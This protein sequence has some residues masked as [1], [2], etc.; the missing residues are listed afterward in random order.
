MR[1]AI[2]ERIAEVTSGL[3]RARATLDA[4]RRELADREGRAE[5]AAEFA[6]LGQSVTGALAACD[7]PREC[8]AQLATLLLRL[9]DL[10]ARF[11]DH[12]EFRAEI[13]ARRTEVSDAFAA[14]RQTLEDAAARRA[15][16]LAD[17]AARV[18][19]TLARRA[20]ALPDREAVATFFASEALVVKARRTADQLRALGESVR[21]EELAGRLAAAREDA[22][23]A[24][25]DRTELYADGGETIR[26]G[27]H[28]F[29][30][31]T[32][33]PELTLLPDADGRV[34]VLALTGTDYRA[35]VSDPAFAATRAYWR[36][37]LPSEAPDVYRAEHLAAR[38]LADHGA[39]ALSAATLEEL[40]EL[41]RR[42][43]EEA[44]DEGYERGVH[45][46]DATAILTAVLRL[47]E[48]AE[49]L[50]YPAGARARAALFWAHGTTEAAS[51]SWAREAVSLARARDAFGSA[52][53]L[54]AL[55][56]ELATTM[57]GFALATPD[58]DHA[59][60]AGGTESTAGDSADLA[61][62]YL[63]EE[64]ARGGSFVTGPTA[65][66]LLAAFGRAVGAAGD[67]PPYGAD[68]RAQLAAG[69][70]AA[71]YR[72][73]HGWLTAYAGAGARS[74]TVT[75]PRRWPSRSVRASTGGR[76]RRS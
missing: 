10:E 64:L 32:Q 70:P 58:A 26:L 2:L 36:Q 20:G 76:W 27:E 53:G 31:S 55:R 42:V 43:A 25:R 66:E 13:D 28:R 18:L 61:A 47:H 62:A 38:L 41:V 52:P 8:D 49:L 57:A 68:V 46:R 11:A 45:D 48:S 29:A 39:P 56:A 44:Y 30:V 17:S 12:E 15:A 33:T 59:P 69:E 4:R 24:L 35:P 54:G 7:D 60:E 63:V 5:F 19:E 65:R 6:L 9:E 22:L 14:R 51:A 75:W 21:A 72:L 16:A 50:R 1:T 3:N 74:R 40:A 34:M 37:T 71:A 73:V 67:V 23:R